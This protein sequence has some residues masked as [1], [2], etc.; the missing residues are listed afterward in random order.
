LAASCRHRGDRLRNLASEF[1]D[2]E[3]A[4]SPVRASGLGLTDYDEGLDDLSE[5]AFVRRRSSDA[6]VKAIGAGDR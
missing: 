5:A 1:L 4:D 2:A 6:D 3:F